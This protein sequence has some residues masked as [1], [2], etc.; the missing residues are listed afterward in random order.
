MQE[1][2]AISKKLCDFNLDYA[3]K[4]R[5]VSPIADWK[6]YVKTYDYEHLE[7][8]AHVDY[9]H[10]LLT[11]SATCNSQ[12][13]TFSL[14]PKRFPFLFVKLTPS[15]TS[16]NSEFVLSYAFALSDSLNA[17][18]RVNFDPRA[19]LPSVDL[20]I[21]GER[22]WVGLRANPAFSPAEGRY[23]LGGNGAVSLSFGSFAADFILERTENG[24]A[25]GFKLALPSTQCGIIAAPGER[26]RL[27]FKQLI[28]NQ[29]AFAIQCNQL[30]ELRH[31]RWKTFAESSFGAKWAF[32]RGYIGG[33]WKVPRSLCGK[34]KWCFDGLCDVA[35]AA[36]VDNYEFGKTLVSFSICCHSK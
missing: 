28:G 24:I 13:T 35:V 8:R 1:I 30:F 22:R 2:R 19:A 34:A 16:L 25:K 29:F 20:G 10:D 23:R 6:V 4:V 5:S 12:Q 3:V 11:V 21:T 32:S 7:N 18:C 31:S 15:D 27:Y 36:N 9:F 26:G 14:S 33:A 17:S